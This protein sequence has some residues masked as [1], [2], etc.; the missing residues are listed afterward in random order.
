[1][2]QTAAPYLVTSTKAGESPEMFLAEKTP[3]PSRSLTAE[4]RR[5]MGEVLDR[6]VVTTGEH[7][8]VRCRNRAV[9]EFVAELAERS[10]HRVGRA[11][12]L[13][14]DP[15]P[16][17]EIIVHPTP[18]VYRAA[19]GKPLLHP[20]DDCIVAVATDAPLPQAQVPVVM[21][22]DIE[23]IANVLQAEALPRELIGKANAAPSTQTTRP[24]DA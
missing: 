14:I 10:L 13:E 11:I 16:T 24:R 1:M 19:V 23:T 20:D 12:P 7:F 21:L 5:D 15:V 22:D 17:V 6:E 2:D 4:Q 9:G 8:T 3:L 18:A